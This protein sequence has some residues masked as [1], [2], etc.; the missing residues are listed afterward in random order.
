MKPKWFWR[1]ADKTQEGSE[2]ILTYECQ[3]DCCEL[4]MCTIKVNA[5]N[6]DKLPEDCIKGGQW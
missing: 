6:A 1:L 4:P 5:M 2:V 3:M